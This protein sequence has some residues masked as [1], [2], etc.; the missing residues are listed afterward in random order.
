LHEKVQL[1]LA[2]VLSVAAYDAPIVAPGFRK[3]DIHACS[4]VSK[5]SVP[6]RM[7][8]LWVSGDPLWG[9]PDSQIWEGTCPGEQV[10]SFFVACVL[11]WQAQNPQPSVRV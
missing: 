11:A 8:R 7:L 4:K 3:P 2:A 9:K 5:A 10:P 6:I 1:V